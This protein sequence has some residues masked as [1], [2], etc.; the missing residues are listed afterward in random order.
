M[1]ETYK[2]ERERERMRQY[3]R[4]VCIEWDEYHY[5]RQPLYRLREKPRKEREC[6]RLVVQLV[7]YNVSGHYVW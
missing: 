1:L 6:T 3:N 5:N 7:Q 2:G 4:E